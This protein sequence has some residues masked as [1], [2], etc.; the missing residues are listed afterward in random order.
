MSQP[1]DVKKTAREARRRLDAG[2]SVAVIVNTVRD[3]CD[4]F[5]QATQ[6]GDTRWRFLAATMLPGHKAKIIADIRRTLRKSKPVGVV[7]TQVLEAGVD[8]SFDSLL[9]ALPVFPSVVQAAGRANRHGAGHGPA[10]VVVFDYRR[11]EA[12]TSREFIYKNEAARRL[13]DE[14]L[15]RRTPLAEHDVPAALTEYFDA[16]WR[17]D[18]ATASLDRFEEAARGAWSALAGLEPFEGDDSWRQDVFVPDVGGD[19]YLSYRMGRML[20]RWA[21]DGPAQL[22]ECYQDRVFRR[23]LS[24]RQ[25]KQLTAL[26]RQFTVAMPKAIAARIA[27]PTDLDW[28]RLLANP[29]DYSET[30]GLAHHLAG[31]ADEA[32][33]III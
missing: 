33:A 12:K 1:W 16:L 23:S 19:R 11:A 9:R 6:R 32:K 8:L 13:T 28:L 26:L 29:T 18:P 24:F 17:A 10:E 3:A 25:K 15:A 5:T 31:A 2:R 20:Y 22:L 27:D 14:V 4:V 7:C 30:T 21:P